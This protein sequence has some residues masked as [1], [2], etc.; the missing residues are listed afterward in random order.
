MIRLN[1]PNQT[2]ESTFR[3]SEVHG[4]WRVSRGQSLYGDFLTRGDAVRAACFG[5]RAANK[6]GAMSRVVAAPEDHRI[7]PYEPHFGD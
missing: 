3:V 6:R 5:A 7:D 1:D 2:E 4:V